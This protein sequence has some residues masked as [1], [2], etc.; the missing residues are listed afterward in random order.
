[1]DYSFDFQV[2]FSDAF[3]YGARWISAQKVQVGRKRMTQEQKEGLTS[4]LLSDTNV[5]PLVC[6]TGWY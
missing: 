6:A 1:M 4:M 5:I 2:P 3:L